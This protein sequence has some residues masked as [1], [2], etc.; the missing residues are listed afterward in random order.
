MRLRMGSLRVEREGNLSVRGL[1]LGGLASVSLLGCAA[2]PITL[3]EAVGPSPMRTSEASAG[4]PPA[5]AVGAAGEGR[6]VVYSCVHTAT[7]EQSEYPVHT[8]YTLLDE[9]GTPLRRIENRSGPFGASPQPV[10]LRAGRY[11]VRART[12]DGERV[13]LPVVIE[14]GATTEIALDGSAL[15]RMPSTESEQVRLPDGH[16]VG[17]RAH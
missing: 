8:A 7:A 6:L 3:S 2:N 9:H 14:A 5:D 4:V 15:E 13:V 16:V 1:L 12:L 17:W 11:R 10:T